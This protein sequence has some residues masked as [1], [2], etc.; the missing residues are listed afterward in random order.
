MAQAQHLEREAAPGVVQW[1]VLQHLADSAESIMNSMPEIC[2]I[3]TDREPY[4]PV[5]DVGGALTEENMLKMRNGTLAKS[6]L[7][8]SMLGTK[9][10]KH[11]S[12]GI[13][14]EWETPVVPRYN[15][16]RSQKVMCSP[17][18]GI[19]TENARKALEAK[20]DQI[21]LPEGFP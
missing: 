14:I 15:G 21:N 1:A 13:D 16:Q 9:P 2:L 3:T 19:E 10:I 20:V 5:P 8:E 7:I 12:D 17:A 4:V 11:V 18:S 6:D